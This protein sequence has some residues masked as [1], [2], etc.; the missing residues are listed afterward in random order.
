[1]DEIRELDC[2]T[3]KENRLVQSD[4]IPVPLVGVKFYGE[5]SWIARGL[6]RTAEIHHGG[7]SR[8]HRSLL[9][10]GAEERGFR[11][12]REIGACDKHALDTRAA[13]VNDPFR[14]SFA[15]EV[16]QLLDQIHV[17]KHD[18]PFWTSDLRV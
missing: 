10:R 14:N 15:I 2:V 13:R 9:A 5:P 1:M 16:G 7:E 6:G 8:E 18:W 3:D 11:I 12:L 17:F 4:E